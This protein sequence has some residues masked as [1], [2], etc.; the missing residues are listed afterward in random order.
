LVKY[1]SFFT[2]CRTFVDF[3]GFVENITMMYVVIRNFEMKQDSLQRYVR[4]IAGRSHIPWV[5]GDAVEVTFMAMTMVINIK[6]L[7][8]N[9]KTMV[10]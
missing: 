4:G 6:K 9:P 8:Y 5:L 3:A 1:P 7:G 2:W 10:I